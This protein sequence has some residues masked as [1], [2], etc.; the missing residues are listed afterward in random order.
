MSENFELLT[1][2]VAM[3]PSLKHSYEFFLTNA[4]TYAG[5][6][7]TYSGLQHDGSGSD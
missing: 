3:A 7:E 1:Q 6:S 2:G 5:G 4:D